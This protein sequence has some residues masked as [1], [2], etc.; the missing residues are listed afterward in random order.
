MG[1]RPSKPIKKS[2]VYMPAFL[3]RLQLYFSVCTPPV[4]DFQ[5]FS[6]SA[7]NPD[8]FSRLPGTI[9][10]K[11]F[12]DHSN[13]CDWTTWAGVNRFFASALCSEALCT[14]LFRAIANLVDCS[15]S[16]R[17]HWFS[18]E[19]M[20][21]TPLLDSFH[22]TRQDTRRTLQLKAV[23]F[24]P[25]RSGKTELLKCI[26]EQ[27]GPNLGDAG[28]GGVTTPPPEPEPRSPQASAAHP[29]RRRP[30]SAPSSW[31]GSA[32]VLLMGRLVS[33]NL[34]E[35]HANPERLPL[36]Q[37]PHMVIIVIDLA[38]SRG[39]EEAERWYQAF[40]RNGPATSNSY[41]VFVGTRADHPHRKISTLAAL[42]FARTHRQPRFAANDMKVGASAARSEREA[43]VDRSFPCLYLECSALGESQD[44]D[45]VHRM[46]DET[47]DQDRSESPSFTRDD[48][49]DDL[50]TGSRPGIVPKVC[51]ARH[52]SLDEEEGP[53][54]LGGPARHPRLPAVL[55]GHQSAL[56]IRDGPT[57]RPAPVHSLIDTTLVACLLYRTHLRLPPFAQR[58]YH[59][60]EWA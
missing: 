41:A 36:L 48:S 43:A 40:L 30:P 45:W 47:T 25:P 34:G 24:G 59:L 60:E 44:H 57:P 37:N 29:H 51:R 50:M 3:R 32:T 52:M 53:R 17:F 38:R 11:I 33:L 8:F 46:D 10:L 2:S 16:Y 14:S 54:T 18:R 22:L 42:A 58:P 19:V 9:F 56:G 5:K 7:Q 12:L 31:G 1:P 4:F 15:W 28:P 49:F 26:L 6:E 20:D 13:P 35:S 21:D 55:F 27:L 23:V 39:L